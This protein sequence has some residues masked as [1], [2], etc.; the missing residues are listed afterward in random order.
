MRSRPGTLRSAKPSGAPSITDLKAGTESAWA[1][2]VDVLGPPL[3]GFAALRGSDDPDETLAQVFH[4]LARGIDTFDGDWESLRTLAFVIA[5]RRVVDDIRYR[6]RRPAEPWPIDAIER[7]IIG[8]DVE[9][10]AMA[11]LDRERLLDLLAGL[12]PTQRDV[13]T[14]RI[15]SGLTVREVA[16]IM[17]SS[18]HAVKANQR[19]AIAAL[20]R[21]VARTGSTAALPMSAEPTGE[22]GV[23]P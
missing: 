2:A 14:M 9:E 1:Q 19:R 21:E 17:D 13:L 11:N 23:V 12:T 4:D 3:R 18:V 8:G 15:V 10:E 5:R 16:A 20:R 6:T 7:R 22:L